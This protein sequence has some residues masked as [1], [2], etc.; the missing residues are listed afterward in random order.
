MFNKIYEFSPCLISLKNGLEKQRRFLFKEQIGEMEEDTPVKECKLNFFSWREGGR[1]FYSCD[2][3]M[4]SE[5]EVSDLD[6]VRII[7]PWKTSNLYEYPSFTFCDCSIL[8]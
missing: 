5:P 2:D 1:K 6:P 4:D 3:W 8:F 7:D